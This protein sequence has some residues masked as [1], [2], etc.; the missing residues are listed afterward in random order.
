MP[1]GFDG[2]GGQEEE[3]GHIYLRSLSMVG[4]K[5]LDRLLSGGLE[6]A[7]KGSEQKSLEINV[8][9][10]MAVLKSGR[11][12]QSRHCGPGGGRAGSW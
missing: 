1:M 12:A 5:D 11:G 2:L 7:G 6:G 4:T 10:G 3:S 8:G 9:P